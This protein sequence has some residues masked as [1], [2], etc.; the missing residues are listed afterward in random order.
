MFVV[1][2]KGSSWAYATPGFGAPLGLGLLRQLREMA[3]IG[4]AA[5]QNKCH[6]EV[7]FGPGF[8]PW[9]IKQLY[10]SKGERLRLSPPA[11]RANPRPIVTPGHDAP[12]GR[13]PRRVHR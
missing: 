8:R 10:A 6:T 2:D 4:E 12:H 13:G 11:T 1:N 3:G 5:G 9:I 7:R